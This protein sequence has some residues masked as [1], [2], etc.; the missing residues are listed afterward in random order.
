LVNFE[1][2]VARG[3]PKYGK[4][5]CEFESIDNSTCQKSL[6]RGS[7]QWAILKN[8]TNIKHDNNL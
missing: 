6:W 8:Y 5:K 2:I 4:L 1:I 3:L 7:S